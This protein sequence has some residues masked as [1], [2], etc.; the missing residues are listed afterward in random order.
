VLFRSRL[1]GEDARRAARAGYEAVSHTFDG[2]TLLVTYKFRGVPREGSSG[3]W[4]GLSR[5]GLGVMLGGALVALGPVLLW[6][7]VVDSDGVTLVTRTGVEGID[8]LVTI[9]IGIGIAILGRT[10]IRGANLERAGLTLTASALT[11]VFMIADYYEITQ[12]GG[13]TSIGMFISTL[14]ALVATTSS[15]RL[16]PS[17]RTRATR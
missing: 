6:A 5:S 17:L 11:F 15:L 1:F 9:V 10:M 13:T 8:G 12:A 3:R 4:S 7:T 14:G 2:N 16:R